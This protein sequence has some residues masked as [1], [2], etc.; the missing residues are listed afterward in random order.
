MTTERASVC[1]SEGGGSGSDEPGEPPPG[2]PDGATIEVVDRAGTS[3]A[4]D[5]AWI[6][7]RLTE[8]APNLPRAV[9]AIDLILVGED[10]MAA[11]HARHRGGHTVT[12]VLAFDWSESAGEPARVEAEIIACVDVASREAKRR[13]HPVEREMLLYALHGLLHCCG[14]NDHTARDS[15]AMHA[16]EDRILECIGVGPT[17]AAEA[18]PV[19]GHDDGCDSSDRDMDVDA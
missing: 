9:A 1:E 2:Q 8:M 14:H 18:L 3:E 5:L 7:R 13:G 15:A 4:L 11:L 10:E 6:R 17:F 16:E 19:S 12:D